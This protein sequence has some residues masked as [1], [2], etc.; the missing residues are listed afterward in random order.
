L[1]LPWAQ[2]GWRDSVGA[3]IDSVLGELGIERT[4]HIE[5]LRQL[6]WAAVALVRTAEGDVYFK[7]SAPSEAFEPPLTLELSR[8]RPDVV[9]AVVGIEA[10][11]AWM[12][13]RDAGTHLRDRIT[14]PPDPSIWHEL[15]PLYA[16]LQI[17]LTDSADELLA[18]GAP[19][20]RPPSVALAY[21]ELLARWQPET[22]PAQAEVDAL[23]DGLGDTIP[24]SLVHEEFGDHN[25]LVDGGDATVIDWA[26]AS[27]GHPFTGLVNT[28]RGLV[29]RWGFQPGDPDLLRLRDLYLEPWTHFAP[30]QKLTELFALAYPFGMLCRALTWDRLVWTLPDPTRAE[31]AHFVPAWLEMLTETL[32]GKA[33]LGT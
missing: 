33:T 20:S 13:T 7:A 4:G 2:P 6:P 16:E 5:H 27:I 17:E 31:Y 24:I 25:I 11:Q 19:D 29:D 32:E 12:L 22:A 23:A 3:W 10:E 26:E 15:L 30:P 9:P 18:L 8:R 28:F 1:E 14:D 21:D